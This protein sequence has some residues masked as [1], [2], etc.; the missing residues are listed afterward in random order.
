MRTTLLMLHENASMADT[1]TAKADEGRI[2]GAM[3]IKKMAKP[4]PLTLWI[5]LAAKIVAKNCV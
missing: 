1:V 5:M 4:K 3:D 2:N